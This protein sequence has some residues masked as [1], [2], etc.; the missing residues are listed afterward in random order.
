VTAL[1]T[2]TGAPGTPGTI[3]CLMEGVDRIVG[4]D[5]RD[6]PQKGLV[7]AFHVVPRPG[8]GYIEAMI[9]VCQRENVDVILPQTT[10][11][12]E[13]LS[14]TKHRN[15]IRRESGA[16]VAAADGF[17][18]KAAND[19][20]AVMALFHML[21]LPAPEFVRVSSIEQL[22][23]A[24]VHFG[25]P[26]HPFVVKPAC[27]NGSRGVR[28]VTEKRWD[29][30]RFLDEKPSGL[31]TDLRS[32]ELVL[33]NDFPDLIAM[34]YLPGSEYSVDCFRGLHVQEAVPRLRKETRGGICTHAVVEM[35]DG[36]REW[37]LL[38]AK[39]LGLFGA[40]GFQYRVDV[41]GTPKVIECNPRV[42]GTMVTSLYK[43]LNAPLL[44][45]R[46]AMGDHPTE[47]T[48]NDDHVE[49]V[50]VWS[51]MEVVCESQS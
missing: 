27:G 26:D 32:L 16:V 36:L 29:T 17:A 21:K 31:E 50:R 20:G 35:R 28:V 42:Q 40:F 51:G 44:A 6:V 30:R 46:E 38:A 14:R 48:L 9:E 41:D 19:K 8:E 25:W 5:C 47:I 49:Y 4:V 43:G 22:Q 23:N 34:E 45:V 11:E 13:Y 3:A 37:S 7:D 33:K 10:A 12:V 18:V 24:A 1:L 2:G 39:H 15:R